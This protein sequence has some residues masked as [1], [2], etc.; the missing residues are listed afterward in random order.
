MNPDVEPEGMSPGALMAAALGMCTGMHVLG[1]L[2]RHD[3]EHNGYE[4]TVDN[5]SG[6]APRRCS[7]YTTTIKLKADL[8]E[9]QME[10]LLAEASR[11]YVGNTIR[12]E[13]EVQV[14]INLD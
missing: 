6:E 5:E 10:S 1:W 4:I 7:K 11:C 14:N 8:D 12:A 2:K 9:K 13:T 3:V